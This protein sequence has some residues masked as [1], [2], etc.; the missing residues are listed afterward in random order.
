MKTLVVY[1][2]KEEYDTITNLAFFLKH[3]VVH[4]RN[5][6]YVFLINNKICSLDIEE[7][8]SIRVF[9][10]SQ[11]EYDLPSYKWF[12][13]TMIKESPEYFD[14]F[15]T[16]YF[17][18]SSCIGP[19]LPTIT[20]SNWIELFNKKL[21]KYDL[22]APIVE[23]PPDSYGFTLLGISSNLNVPFLHSYM[24]GTNASSFNLLKNLLLGIN[25]VDQSTIINCERK[26]TSEYLIHGK[27]IHSLLIAFNNIDINDKSLWNY[28]LW[29]KNTVTCYEVPENYFGIDINP[30]EVVFIKN[31]RKVHS[32]RNMH[33]SGISRYL[34]TTLMNYITWY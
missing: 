29:N 21:E 11:N 19:F 23:F 28:K 24:F 32:F 4:S 10:R 25:T 1:C 16:F 31:I 2:Y 13:E 6:H 14:Q 33:V 15:G 26:L 12:I 7:T 5:Y 3:G 18:N 22:I 8:S 9:K 34:Y 20:E 17:L 30:L 27:K